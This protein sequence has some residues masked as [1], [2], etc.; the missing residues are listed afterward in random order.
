MPDSSNLRPA[1]RDDRPRALSFPLRLDSRKRIRDADDIIPISGPATSIV[2]SASA[3]LVSL[4]VSAHNY[5]RFLA[6]CIDSIL[7]QSYPGIECIVVDD[8]STDETGEVLARYADRIRIERHAVAQGQLAAM[9]TGFRLAQGQF[10]SFVDADDYLYPDFVLAHVTVF[11]SSGTFAAMSSSSQHN[12]DVAGRALGIHPVGTHWPQQRLPRGTW[13]RGH[14]ASTTLGSIPIAIYDPQCNFAHQWLWGTSTSMMFRRHVVGQIFDPPP[15]G[16]RCF[17]DAYLAQFCHAIGGTVVIELPLSAYRRH[18]GNI[19]AN[20]HMAGGLAPLSTRTHADQDVTPLIARQLAM[21]ARKF[22]HALGLR[23]F[24]VTLEKFGSLRV[25][26]RMVSDPTMEVGV[27]SLLLF[28]MMRVSRSV[29]IRTG[30]LALLWAIAR[31][32]EF[33]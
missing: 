3:P 33:A 18:G 13:R 15:Q 21:N 22:R 8:G 19:Y 30:R 29:R 4:C 14:V 32:R 2:G 27:K 28:L 1:A 6:A 16:G 20:N 5:G 9:V 25:M 31:L 26:L 11:M 7:A 17:G 23:R 10:V 24:V 12:V